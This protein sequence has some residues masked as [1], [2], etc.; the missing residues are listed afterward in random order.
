MKFVQCPDVG[1]DC[2]GY[3]RVRFA[4]KVVPRIKIPR[5]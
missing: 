1:V 4:M 3:G 5:E 2:A